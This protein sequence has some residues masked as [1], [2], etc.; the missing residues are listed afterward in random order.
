MTQE[1]LSTMLG[2]RRVAVSEAAS[3]FQ[4]RK[5]IEYRRGRIRIVDHPGL[6]AACCN[7]YRGE[8]D[9]LPSWRPSASGLAATSYEPKTSR[10]GRVSGST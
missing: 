8:P 3:A 4:R 10:A 2:V 7:C 1:F 6:E 5:L 9:T